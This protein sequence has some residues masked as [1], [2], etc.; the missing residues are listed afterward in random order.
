MSNAFDLGLMGRDA[1][2]GGGG[3]LV[4]VWFFKV[5]DHFRKLPKGVTSDPPLDGSRP[6][7]DPA[8]VPRRSGEPR[9][10]APS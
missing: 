5:V 3:T 4:L 8:P 6:A 2:I 9:N 10:D 1:L 7:G